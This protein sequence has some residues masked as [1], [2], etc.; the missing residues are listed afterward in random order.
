MNNHGSVPPERLSFE[1]KADLCA[2]RRIYSIPKLNY[3]DISS[4]EYLAEIMERWPLLAE[5]AQLNT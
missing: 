3:I 1:D 5:L 2:L 4:Q